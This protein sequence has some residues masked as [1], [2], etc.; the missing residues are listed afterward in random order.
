MAAAPP[1]VEVLIVTLCEAKRADSLREAIATTLSQDGVAASLIVVVNGARY[2][3]ALFEALRQMAG[4]RVLYQAEPSI[5]LARRL[6]RE[7]VTAPYFGFLDDDD[8]LLPGAL[9]TR[10]D[11][12]VAQPGAD[13]VVTNGM[14]TGPDGDGPMLDDLAAIRRDPLMSLMRGNWL[15]TASALF[16]TATIGP[17][18]FDVAIRSN[19]MTYLAFRLGLERQV[20]FLDAPTYRKTYSPDS[21]S[22]T[23][24]W[25]LPSLDTLERMLALDMPPAVRTA[26]RLRCAMAAHDIADIYLRRG[27]LGPAW[28]YHLRSLADPRG[29]LR[30]AAFTRRLVFAPARRGAA[31]Q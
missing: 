20:A 6:A 1:A 11:A 15:A 5:F 27:E 31:A 7:A 4:V 28:R 26:L 30:Y 22:L 2:D 25:A 16:R 21:I 3:G 17:D 18:Y 9:R 14:L 12:F 19:D 23:E 24:A 13:A 10:V 29:L 8:A